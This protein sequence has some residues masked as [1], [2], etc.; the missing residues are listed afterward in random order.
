MIRHDLSKNSKSRDFKFFSGGNLEFLRH[1]DRRL[2]SM[3]F[4][5]FCPLFYGNNV[6]IVFPH[7]WRDKSLYLVTAAAAA[8]LLYYCGLKAHCHPSMKIMDDSRPLCIHNDGVHMV[9]NNSK[10]NREKDNAHS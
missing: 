1:S 8:W 2:T 5:Q 3:D 4:P 7:L 6:V 10:K 9:D